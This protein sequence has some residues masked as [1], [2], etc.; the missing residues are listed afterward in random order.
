MRTSV[1]TVTP[2]TTMTEARSRRAT[3]LA[4]ISYN[5]SRPGGSFSYL[6]SQ[7]LFAIGDEDLVGPGPR[8][9]LVEGPE[10]GPLDALVD[11]IDPSV[12]EDDGRRHLVG[13]DVL[14]LAV[15]VLALV[16]VEGAQRLVEDV[17]DLRVLEEGAVEATRR[18]VARVVERR[19]VGVDAPVEADQEHVERP[20]VDDLRHEL[21]ELN[22]VRRGVDAD[23]LP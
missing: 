1:I 19:F 6:R 21:R 17:V 16:L 14:E 11:A 10:V 23:V 7:M 4:S 8:S 20:G 5:P 13:H 3:Y 9:K 15:Q 22:Q 18:C 2:K 12:E